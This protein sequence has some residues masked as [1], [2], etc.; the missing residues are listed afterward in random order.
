MYKLENYE[1]VQTFIET[2]VAKDLSKEE[3]LSK[4]PLIL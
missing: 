3:I 2:Y 4:T 1:E